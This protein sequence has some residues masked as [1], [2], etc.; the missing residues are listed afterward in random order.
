MP[1][2]WKHFQQATY[3]EIHSLSCPF[4]SLS[5]SFLALI[6]SHRR[7]QLP[8]VCSKLRLIARQHKQIPRITVRCARTVQEPG[9]GSNLVVWLYQGHRIESGVS[10]S[11]HIASRMGELQHLP[12]CKHY[13]AHLRPCT[14]ASLQEHQGIDLRSHDNKLRAR[15]LVQ[16][17]IHQ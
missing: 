17:T 1:Y 11:M 8:A 3:C 7:W 13:R 12:F 6:Q 16:V 14:T 5:T 10:A 9:L 15:E 2:G 4:S